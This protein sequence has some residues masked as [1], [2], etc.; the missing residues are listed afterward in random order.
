M[1]IKF[2]DNSWI[3]P[4]SCSLTLMLPP[5]DLMPTFYSI[6]LTNQ[7]CHKGIYL[8]IKINPILDY[9]GSRLTATSKFARMQML[10]GSGY[11]GSGHQV[12]YFEW[13]TIYII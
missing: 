11:T 5:A 2:R 6:Y 13:D 7:S 12:G 8:A 1:L 9:T 10:A 3:N 4:P